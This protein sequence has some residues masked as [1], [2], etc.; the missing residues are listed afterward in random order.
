MPMKIFRVWFEYTNRNEEDCQDFIT[1]K[2]L[3]ESC[4]EINGRSELRAS[5]Q[6]LT[7][8]RVEATPL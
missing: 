7:F 4:A 2:A 1:V 3:N 5:R 8:V 6:R